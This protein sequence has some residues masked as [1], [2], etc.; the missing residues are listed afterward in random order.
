MAEITAP[1][2]HVRSWPMALIKSAMRVTW[3]PIEALLAPS[4]FFCSP[5]CW[6]AGGIAD[7]TELDTGFAQVRQVADKFDGDRQRHVASVLRF[8]TTAARW[9]SS[10]APERPRSR[11]RSKR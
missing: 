3:L 5:L 2:L 11:M 8:C 4:S 10:R 1:S 6:Q 9:N 7:L